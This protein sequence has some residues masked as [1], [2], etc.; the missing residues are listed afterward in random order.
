[1]TDDN[2]LAT[3]LIA[4]SLRRQVSRLSEDG[5]VPQSDQITVEEPLEIRLSYKDGEKTK[6][7]SISITMRTPGQDEELALGFLIGEAIIHGPEDVANVEHCGPPSPDKG[8]QNVL[9]VDLADSVSVDFEMLKRHFYT[10]SSC[11]VCGKASLEAIRMTV[12]ERDASQFEIRAASLGALPAALLETQDEFARTG[13]LHASACFDNQGNIQRLREDV[14]RHNA[15]D[16][17]VGSYLL[18]GGL[19]QFGVLLSGRAS[20]ELIQKAAMAGVCLVA[21]IGAPSSLAIEL[22]EEQG[23]SL[24]GFLKADG[25]NLYC[26]GQRVLA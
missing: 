15:L 20:F 22:A 6:E 12:P 10:S 2:I 25:F 18:E 5:V 11:G 9:K 23:I 3:P 4:G 26:H 7:Q 1:M 16:K 24:I 21:A 19:S 13:S 14:G 8:L 17:L